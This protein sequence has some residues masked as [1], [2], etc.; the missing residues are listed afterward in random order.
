MK[1]TTFKGKDPKFSKHG[2]PI[3]LAESPF[4]YLNADTDF[5]SDIKFKNAART[6]GTEQKHVNELVDIINNDEYDVEQYPTPFVIYNV[7][8]NKYDLVAGFHRFKAFHKAGHTHIPVTVVEVLPG[9]NTQHAIRK[10]QLW[11][12]RKEPYAKLESSD[13]DIIDTIARELPKKATDDTI[14]EWLG[15]SLRRVNSPKGRR[16]LK[17][18]KKRL[19]QNVPD[20]IETPDSKEKATFIAKHRARFPN[21]NVITLKDTPGFTGG[22]QVDGARYNTAVGDEDYEHRVLGMFSNFYE[23]MQSNDTLTKIANK[24][25]VEFEMF[26]SVDTDKKK[27]TSFEQITEYKS[28]EDKDGMLRQWT[29]WMFFMRE[30]IESGQVVLRF[31]PIPQTEDEL[32]QYNK[33]GSFTRGGKTYDLK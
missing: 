14:R 6:K 31:K 8:T 32:K 30:R 16:L 25:I 15:V 10:L 11:E 18:I 17:A 24:E 2:L 28:G 20:L 33:T 1:H 29:D 5:P 3:K 19:G 7:K 9:H 4:R 22:W 12:N 23:Q 27:N 26:F 21:K 13:N